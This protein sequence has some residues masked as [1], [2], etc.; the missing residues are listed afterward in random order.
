MKLSRSQGQE[1]TKCM[2]N[3]KKMWP[4]LWQFCNFQKYYHILK[5]AWR[6]LKLTKRFTLHITGIKPL[7]WFFKIWFSLFFLRHHNPFD[8]HT[9]TRE[10]ARQ[11]YW[12]YHAL[13][14]QRTVPLQWKS[15]KII[16]WF[17]RSR[18][19]PLN[20]DLKCCHDRVLFLVEGRRSKP[21]LSPR[22]DF[23]G[24]MV[25]QDCLVRVY[26]D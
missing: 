1:G 14:V 4:L 20:W 21:V 8:N 11:T 18:L 2:P 17:T 26:I 9:P 25:M 6:I 13:L 10:L 12:F 5:S 3:Q 22:E 15:L 23:K 16:C 24:K 7:C 19:W